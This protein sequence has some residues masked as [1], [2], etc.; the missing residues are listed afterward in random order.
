MDTIGTDQRVLIIEVSS[1]QSVLIREIPLCIII[2]IVVVVIIVTII[3]VVI[4][5]NLSTLKGEWSFDRN[6][7]EKIYMSNIRRNNISP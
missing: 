4:G 6:T 2:I 3:I 7:N 1:F 5:I